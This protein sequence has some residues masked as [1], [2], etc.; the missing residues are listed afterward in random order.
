MRNFFQ[1]VSGPV[2]SSRRNFLYDNTWTNAIFLPMSLN[3]KRNEANIKNIDNYIIEIRKQYIEFLYTLSWHDNVFT[4]N[5]N[6][7]QINVILKHFQQM[8]LLNIM[9]YIHLHNC[10]M[11][12]LCKHHYLL[13]FIKVEPILQFDYKL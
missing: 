6:N 5:V 8:K 9:Y 10:W 7:T 3:V 11:Y 12:S 2:L 4:V 1:W 13:F